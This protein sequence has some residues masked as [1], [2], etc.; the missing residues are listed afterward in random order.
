[1]SAGEN[2]SG[3]ASGSGVVGASGEAAA[4]AFAVAVAVAASAASS[5]TD[6]TRDQSMRPESPPGTRDAPSAA[7][8][9][10]ST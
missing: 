7:R 2:A 9:T 5:K 6:S 8:S 10:P 4:F 3:A 1:M